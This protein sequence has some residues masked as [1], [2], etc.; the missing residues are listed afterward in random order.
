MQTKSIRSAVVILIFSAVVFSC[1]KKTDVRKKDRTKVSI[2]HLAC[3]SDDPSRYLIYKG[4]VV[5]YSR[6]RRSPNF[7]I[8][9]LEPKQIGPGSGERAKRKNL[10]WADQEKLANQSATSQDYRKSGWDRGHMVPAGDFTWDQSLNDESFVY[11]NISPQNPKLNR[12]RWSALETAM[13]TKVLDEGHAFIITGAIYGGQNDSTI[14]PNKVGVPTDLYKICYLPKQE[15]M[16]AFL[17][18]NYGTKYLPDFT[19]YQVTVDSIESLVKE[20]FYDML[21]DDKESI[22]ES[23]KEPF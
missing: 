14:G 3:E 10:F 13:R 22:M 7:T 17:Y 15:K 18:S 23:S 4:F 9:K 2:E 8:H 16:F 21:P 5:Q 1:S 6:E 20:D 12:G 11:S 19:N